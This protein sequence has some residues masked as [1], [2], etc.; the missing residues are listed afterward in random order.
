M[1]W[2]LKGGW[3]KER[4]ACSGSEEGKQL[5]G[6]DGERRGGGDASPPPGA[7]PRRAVPTQR[8]PGAVA[9]RGKP[10]SGWCLLPP[11]LPASLGVDGL[12]LASS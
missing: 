10:E 7:Q 3:G 5:V 4:T 9:A 12:A 2:G 8:P 1:G 11:H 6:R